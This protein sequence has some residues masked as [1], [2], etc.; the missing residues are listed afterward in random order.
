MCATKKAKQRKRAP[1]NRPADKRQR[2]YEIQPEA[3]IFGVLPQMSVSPSMAR[4]CGPFSGWISSV[5]NGEC[6]L[7]AMLSYD[8]AHPLADGNQEL[9]CPGNAA[10]L[11]WDI[12]FQ[13]AKRLPTKLS[14]ST[15]G[16]DPQGRGKCRCCRSLQLPACRRSFARMNISCH[17]EP[18]SDGAIG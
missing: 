2:R 16:G 10:T 11:N 7:P 18:G 9:K 6:R 4:P 12:A 13:K 14:L 17:R 5:N 8:S 1:A 15:V 3:A